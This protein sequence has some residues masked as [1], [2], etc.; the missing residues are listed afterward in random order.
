LY[1]PIEPALMAGFFLLRV[2]R[3]DRVRC[4]LQPVGC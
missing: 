1:P 4:L 2:D 3:R